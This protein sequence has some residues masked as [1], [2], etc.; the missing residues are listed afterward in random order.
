MLLSLS[1]LGKVAQGGQELPKE[2]LE[3]LIAFLNDPQADE[4]V[5][6]SAARA[7][8]EVAQGGQEL[9]KEALEGLS[10]FSTILRSMIITKNML[11]KP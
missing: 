9:P 1:A 4:Y 3:G 5:K 7:L 11:S 8:G 2:A 6:G 10:H